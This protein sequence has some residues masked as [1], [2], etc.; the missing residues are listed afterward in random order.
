MARYHSLPTLLLEVSQRFSAVCTVADT[1]GQCLLIEAADVLED[2]LQPDTVNNRVF[3]MHGQAAALREVQGF[4]H[5]TL[6]WCWN[7]ACPSSMAVYRSLK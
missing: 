7:I 4:G 2:W 6:R 3:L 5:L 1:D